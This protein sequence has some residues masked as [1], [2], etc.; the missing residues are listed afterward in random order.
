M[1]YLSDSSEIKEIIRSNYSF[2]L[3]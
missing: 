2:Y 3:C 1:K